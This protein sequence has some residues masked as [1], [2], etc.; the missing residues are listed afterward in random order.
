MSCEF[1]AVRF[2]VETAA[3][4]VGYETRFTKQMTVIRGR[5]TVGKSLLVQG[6]LYALGLEALYAT[7]KGTL[8]RAMTVE[9]DL[10]REEN[11]GV[12][13]HLSTAPP[14]E[15]LEVERS[16]IE[17][18]VKGPHGDLM[19]I[20]RMVKSPG[21][22]N[23]ADVVRVWEG[24][25]F[26]DKID[27]RASSEDYLVGRPGT[28][29]KNRGFHRFL[30]E[31]F[32]W[33]LP[34]VSTYSGRTVPLYLQVIFGL[35]YIDQKR[36]WGG[37]VPQVPTS[38]QIIDPLSK[39]VAFAL[40][41]DVLRHA[42]QRQEL[43]ERQR[44]LTNQEERWRGRLEAIAAVHAGR[45]RFQPLNKDLLRGDA[46]DAR[47]DKG[48][49]GG[50]SES[51]AQQR[52]SDQGLEPLNALQD[53]TTEAEALTAP[54]VEVLS[55]GVWIQLDSRIDQLR[56]IR[57]A[58]TRREVLATPDALAA[59]ALIGESMTALQRELTEAE[60]EL[61]QSSSRLA[62]LNQDEDFLDVQLGALQR[63]LDAL[64][65]EYDRYQQLDVLQELGSVIAPQTMGHGDCPTCHQSLE[66]IESLEGNALPVH[67]TREAIR[68]DRATVRSLFTEAQQ[69]VEVVAAHRAAWSEQVTAA[70]LR[71][72]AL[73]TDLVAAVGTPSTS[74]IQEAVQQEH[75]FARLINLESQFA[76]EASDWA[77][78]A[79]ELAAVN[80][81]L[82]ALGSEKQTDRD[83]RRIAAWVAGLRA[84]LS[85]FGFTSVNPDEVEIDL[86]MKP[87][88]DGY[89]IGFQGSASDGIRLRWAYIL[90]LMEACLLNGGAHPGVLLMDEPGQQ[91]VEQLSLGAL[92]NQL[93]AMST[94]AGQVFVTTSEPVERIAEWIGDNG[95]DLI[96]LGE[97]FLLR[98]LLAK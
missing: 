17:V 20:R 28:A 13:P 38:F 14:K 32:G 64:D 16:W 79:S 94:V 9:V 62:S 70:R 84:K 83:A 24:D 61:A 2:H 93:L 25:V 60:A 59:P 87:V 41:L 33:E 55:N 18:V 39:A 10:A 81:R 96:D 21:A 40:Q 1:R 65:D 26:S 52:R 23:S 3:G 46:I 15:T 88:V 19:T 31:F 89:D 63:R 86:G 35:A 37:T 44:L 85:N 12:T 66:A 36:G 92:F 56:A 6:L 54:V 51:A 30:A 58:R 77:K 75:E 73:K 42:V 22:A 45:V 34:Q 48:P 11:T 71:I 74:D 91:G 90:S 47:S 53:S 72:R 29:V 67:A 95:Y 8:T 98:P 57:K 50:E 80:N 68:Q 82:S 78:V 27:Q 4:P 7:R 69:R 49:N 43:T 97:E 5:N 76:R